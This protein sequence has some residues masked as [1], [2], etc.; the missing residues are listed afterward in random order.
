MCIPFLPFASSLV[1][2]QDGK[3][4]RCVTFVVIQ[5]Y[6]RHHRYVCDLFTTNAQST[7][8]GI[9][10]LNYYGLEEN[11]A[12]SSVSRWRGITSRDRVMIFLI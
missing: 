5:R 3:C 11:V 12:Y 7:I 6:L 9:I 10:F 1:S 4:L 2:H 8:L